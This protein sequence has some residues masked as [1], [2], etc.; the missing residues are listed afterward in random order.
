[1][2]T[3]TKEKILGWGLLAALIAIPILS[4]HAESKYTTHATAAAV[5]FGPRNGPRDVTFVSAESDKAASFIVIQGR[6]NKANVLLAVTNGATAINIPN[7]TYAFTNGDAVV[8]AHADGTLDYTT[9]SGSSTTN[10]T[11]AAGVSKAG[12]TDAVLYEMTNQ[13]RIEL[14]ATNTTASG[15]PLYRSPGDSPIRVSVDGTS[16]CWIAATATD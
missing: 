5:T 9:L 4:A 13:L 12:T 1:M 6:S 16:A 14:G 3:A 15:E 8:F 10:V 11:L 7:A 2:T